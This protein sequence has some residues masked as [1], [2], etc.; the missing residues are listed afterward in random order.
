MLWAK[1][2][3]HVL[4]GECAF[5]PLYGVSAARF[6]L[7]IAQQRKTALQCRQ[8]ACDRVGHV[9]QPADGCNQHEHCRDERDKAAH[10][11]L[12]CVHRSPV[13]PQGDAD[14]RRECG[15]GQQL[16]ER[17]HGR[18]CNGRFDGQPT[19]A[20]AQAAKAFGLTRLRPVQAHHAMRQ[21]V[22][23]HHIGQFVGRLL[24][25]FGQAIQATG[26]RLHDPGDAGHH[27]GHNQC[28]LPVQ[29]K[30][31]AQQCDER[32]AVARQAQQRL[33]QQG[34]ARLYLVHHRVRE[35][36]G[37]LAAEKGHFCCQHAVKQ[38]LPQ[39]EHAF[40]GNARQCVLGNELCNSPHQKNA[41]NGNWHHP[42]LQRAL[43]ETAVEQRLQ[44]GRNERL[45]R[46]AHQGC[47]NGN[48]PGE[49]LVPKI[50]REPRQPGAQVG[51]RSRLGGSGLGV[52]IGGV[53]VARIL[54]FAA[55]PSHSLS[56][57]CPD[58]V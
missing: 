41:Q 35:R 46:C 10:R 52:R 17:R 58:G 9:G 7:G 22:F 50:G 45:G 28:E 11:H 13:L 19:Q 30:Q 57:G 38:R 8:A 5:G 14:H 49:A 34:G 29:V 51:G 40:V 54:R 15:G 47:H 6:C 26:Q 24:A 23:F 4:Q 43:G 21:N 27:H 42:Q 33:H 53:H 55:G 16:G 2:H 39:R 31:I 36:T 12:P 25:A 32:E 37:R 1:A 18:R 3:R 20:S 48:H 44:Q 56:Q